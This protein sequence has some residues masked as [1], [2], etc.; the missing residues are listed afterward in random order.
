MLSTD[1]PLQ[2]PNTYAFIS[3]Q[4]E[5]SYYVIHVSDEIVKFIAMYM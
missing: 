2:L 4:L 1:E 3:S 5:L